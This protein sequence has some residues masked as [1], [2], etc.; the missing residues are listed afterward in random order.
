V[1]AQYRLAHAHVI[2]SDAEGAPATEEESKDLCITPL[3]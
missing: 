2:L 1:G 3:G